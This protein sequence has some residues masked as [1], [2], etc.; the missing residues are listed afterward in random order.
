MRR[1]S[2]VTP[3]WQ[4]EL[5][6]ELRSLRLSLNPPCQSSRV[7]VRASNEHWEAKHR[8]QILNR[9]DQSITMRDPSAS[10]SWCQELAPGG[11][12]LSL[13]QTL[14]GNDLDLFTFRAVPGYTYQFCTTQGASSTVCED[15]TS[16]QNAAELL[17]VGP[18]RA[19]RER[20]GRGS[21]E[22]VRDANGLAWTVPASD[23]QVET[24]A[25]VVRRRRDTR[26]RSCRIT[27]I[28]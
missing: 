10:I 18:G 13:D 14:V 11:D 8:D 1:F 12:Q 26:V 15:E 6:R 17:I 5:P 19:G 9:A 25:V 20:P 28:G 7:A 4:V 23:L 27:H 2:A 22:L 24:Y 3:Y 21:P 16:E